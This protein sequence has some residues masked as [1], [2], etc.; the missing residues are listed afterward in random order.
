MK[1]VEWILRRLPSRFR[2]EYESELREFIACE[3]ASLPAGLRGLPAR[4][5]FWLRTVVDLLRVVVRLRRAAPAPQPAATPAGSE[6]LMQ[7]TRDLRHAARAV[8]TSPV[9]LLIVVTLALAVGLNTA[10]FSVVNAVLLQPFPYE[11]PDRLVWIGAVWDEN[12][13]VR[14]RHS[15]AQF[16]SLRDDAESFADVAAVRS[17]RQNLTG[18]ETPAQVQV[19]WASRNLFDLLGVAPALGH[20]FTEDA[21]AG[22]AVLSHHLWRRDFGLDPDV[23]GRV[24]ELDGYAYEIAGVLPEGFRLYLPG[25]PDRID[26][27][28]V[29]DDWWQNGDVWSADGVEFAILDLVGRLG[30]G[31]TRQQAAHELDGF[32]ARFRELHADFE[33]ARLSYDVVPLQESVVGDSRSY[34]LMLFGAVGLVLLVACANV[35]NLMLSRAHQ[36]GEELALRLALGASR[37]RLV[38]LLL[39]ESLILASLGGVA[40]VALGA[41]CLEIFRVVQPANVARLDSVSLDGPVL[42]FALGI[43]ILSTLVFGLAPAVAA[44][45]GDLAKSALGGRATSTRSRRRFGQALVVGELSMS[46]V[47]LVGAALLAASLGR[48]LDVEPGFDD[49]NLLTFS[50]SLPGTDYERPQGTDRFF[51]ELESRIEELPGVTS[52]GVVWPLPMSGRAWSNRVVGD[53]E[54]EG[55]GRYAQY[56]L[57]TE[58]FFSTMGIS[59][60]EG[61]TFTGSDPRHVVVVSERLADR[62]WPSASAVGRRLQAE[63]WGRGL[64]HYEVIGVVSDVRYRDL[65]SPPGETVYFDSRGWSWTDWEVDFV[66][67]TATEPEALAGPIA[68]TVAALDGS[69]P[70]ARARTM[71]GYV[72]E[73][74][75]PIRFAA[76]LIGLFAVVAGILAAV[77]LYGV[78]SVSVSQ[79]SRELGLRMALGAERSR[80]LRGI[81]LGGLRLIVMGVGVGIAASLYLN[82]FLSSLLHDVDAWDPAA[83]LAVSLLL[84][85]VGVAASTGPARRATKLDPMRVLRA[86]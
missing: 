72:D 58:G 57:A 69:I 53:L 44:T 51:R 38:R 60:V 47:L 43:T 86:E 80:I 82:R 15:G 20:G 67:R 85:A 34:V 30:D 32:A 27:W 83:Y 79:R 39:G 14:G 33:R 54:T 17:I 1:L 46:F 23:V 19:G 63:P 6:S 21:P 62:L 37:S 10:V 18:I 81:L 73:R 64:E 28:K 24:V 36:R 84:A 16:S 7:I 55:G 50:V 76:R 56:R 66:V 48:L 8:A 59:L 12:G 3:R 25:F 11:S 35:M 13:P 61:R 41:S 68:E 49:E 70:M 9:S 31:V 26:V 78:I 52:A 5:R 75:A 29:P 45:R 77:G 2:K 71:R 74:L 4:V 22:T 42:G 65:R 40:G